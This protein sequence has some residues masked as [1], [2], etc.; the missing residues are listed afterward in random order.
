MGHVRVTIRTAN[1][2]RRDEAVE[3]PDAL[4]DTG[5]TFTTIPRAIADQLGLEVLGQHVVRTAAGPVTVDRSYAY[6]DLQGH[7]A[8]SPI[9]ISD[10]Y[11][12]VLIWRLRSR[13]AGAGR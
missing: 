11:P 5:A 7:D 1:P 10:S 13:S 4:V 12:G 3:V 6:V 2:N 9:W 8:V